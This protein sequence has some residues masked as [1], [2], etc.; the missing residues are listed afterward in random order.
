MQYKKNAHMH[1]GKQ[2]HSCKACVHQFVQC[3]D[4]GLIGAA[5]RALIERLLLEGSPCGA[6]AA[7]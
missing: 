4:Q 5:Q 3:S 1:N 7:P 6:F 2:N